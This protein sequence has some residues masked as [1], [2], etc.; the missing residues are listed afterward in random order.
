MCHNYYY[1][2]YGRI[3]NESKTRY[4][5][6]KYVE[7]FDIF[8]LQEY[9]EKDFITKEDIANYLND[10][11]NVYLMNIKDYNDQKTINEF[12]AYCNETIENYNKTIRG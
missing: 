9:F 3:Y 11:E 8:D 5:K 4:R 10:I 2:I 12:Y 7:F 1:L 6:F